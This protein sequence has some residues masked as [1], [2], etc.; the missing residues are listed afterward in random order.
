MS[1]FVRELPG[2]LLLVALGIIL[3]VFV[4]SKLTSL[5]ARSIALLAVFG[6]TLFCVWEYVT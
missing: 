4:E 5:V 3:A 6:F 1:E 2:V